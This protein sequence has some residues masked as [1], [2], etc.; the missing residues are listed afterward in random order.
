MSSA[1]AHPVDHG[2]AQCLRPV[3]ADADQA[4]LRRHIRAVHDGRLVDYIRKACLIAGP[5]SR[6]TLTCSHAEPGAAPKDETVL[7]GYYCID[8]FTRS[9]LTLIS[10][11]ARRSTAR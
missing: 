7:A 9:T 3:R 6:S 8:T 4:L 1:G 2:R 10:P 11:R 5:K